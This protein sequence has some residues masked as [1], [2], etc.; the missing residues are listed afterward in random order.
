[1]DSLD[2]F[3]ISAE[4]AA[5][6]VDEAAD[7][8][9]A[10]WSGRISKFFSQVSAAVRG[11]GSDFGAATTALASLGTLIATLGG[12]KLLR[13]LAAVTL[14]PLAGL[15]VRIATFIGAELASSAAANAIGSN[16]ASGLERVPGVARVKGALGKVGSALGSP[17]GKAIGIATALAFVVWFADE[18]NK[19]R[20]EVADQAKSIGDSVGA[21]IATGTTEQLEQSRA[22]IKSAIDQIVA[23]TKRGP[24]QMATPQQIAAL[25]ALVEQYNRIQTELN[26]RAVID[27]GLAAA[28]LRAATPATE[29]AARNLSE[30]LPTALERGQAAVAS[31]AELWA[32][33]SIGE[34][35]VALGHE[36][37]IR[38][39]QA[40]L[41]LA[42]GLRDR[43]SAVTA[44]MDQL[45]TDLKNAM[46]PKKLAAQDIGLLF[47]K[48][49]TKG[50][51]SSDPVVRAQ[52]KATRA[53]LEDELIE[54]VKAG[55]EAGT[56][57]LEELNRKMKS[58][59]PAVADQAKRTKSVIDA[60]LKAN[61]AA[62]TPGDV[63][64]DQLNADLKDK[65]T[66]LGRTA[67]TIGRTIAKNLLA[68]VKGTGYVAPTS[69]TG[70]TGTTYKPPVYHGGTGYVPE[71]QLAM[72]QR[73]EIIVPEPTASAIRSGEAVLGGATGTN[74]PLIGQVMVDARGATDP[75]ATGAAVK[76]G[77]ADA[78]ADVFRDQSIRGF[79][80]T[81][82]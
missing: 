64:G 25:E 32:N 26:E 72:V 19:R 36:A 5:G 79:T 27:A 39:A 4:E 17:L 41:D 73:G 43:R 31:A 24:I 10:T 8:L 9:D 59:D 37:R 46:S 80:G 66:T 30:V 15:G 20:Q 47:G 68:G 70:I 12:G 48:D 7:A 42:S 53:L 21:Q 57:I 77:I 81:S 22:A 6:A 23:D 2:D 50:L 1:M 13:G 28:A 82:L 74:G 58:K 62:K 54:T 63:I 69:S 49:L 61:T 51:K 33:K 56:K 75:A 45:R 40:A 67:Y 44:A 16:L 65:G 60:A 11:F 55:G 76:Q 29:A 78:M 71:T 14:K 18:L 35:L 52:A 38:G 34:K 3:K